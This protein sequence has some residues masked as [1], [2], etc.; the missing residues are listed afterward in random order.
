MGHKKEADRR[1]LDANTRAVPGKTEVEAL[2][3][4]HTRVNPMN[5]RGYG[6]LESKREDS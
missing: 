4:D 3:G 5:R 2:G 1:A 6:L